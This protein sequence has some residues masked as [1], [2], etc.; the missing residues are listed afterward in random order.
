MIEFKN[1]TKTYGNVKAVDN[2][3][4]T[5]EKGEFICLIGTSGSGKTTTM[6]MI[7]RMTELTS[8]QITVNGTDIMTLDPVK[9]RRELGYV[10]QNIGLLPHMTIKENITMVPTLLKWDNQR[11]EEIARKMI[12][13]AELPEEFLHRYPAELSGG[14]QQRIGVVRAL[15]ADQD[16]I[17]MD[18]PFGAL[19]PITR[20]SLQDLVKGLQEDLG[21]TIV[22]VTHDM[23]EALSLATRIVIMSEGKIIQVGTPEEIL[24]NPAND[25]VVDF[26]GKDRLIESRPD[27]ITVGQVMKKDPVSITSGKSLKEAISVMRNAKVDTLLVT[28]D[29]GHLKGNITLQDVQNNFKTQTSVAD[30]VNRNLFA[31]RENGLLRDSVERILKVGLPYVPIVDANNALVGIITRSTLVDVV[32]DAIW[33]E[34]DF[35]VGDNGA[36]KTGETPE[37]AEA[38]AKTNT[39]EWHPDEEA[40]ETRAE[41]TQAA[42]KSVPGESTLTV[43]VGGKMPASSES[44]QGTDSTPVSLPT[45]Q[46]K[47]GGMS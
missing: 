25:F 24:Q 27:V 5:I 6:R 31:L 34:G 2:F 46:D 23:D 32:Y 8:G 47:E 18:E 30:I 37:S 29:Q 15:A 44:P 39:A 20:Q 14:Q 40:R 28:D 16:I 42:D 7:N 22:F 4:L 35:L 17:L 12:K 11:K 43:T 26:I 9:L 1:V 38:S 33:G 19:D 10:I 45:A 41:T 13:L 21:K 36:L 3:N